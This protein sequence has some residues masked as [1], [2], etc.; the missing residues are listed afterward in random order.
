MDVGCYVID[1]NNVALLSMMKKSK[2]KEGST[3]RDES[4][5]LE[6]DYDEINSMEYG[7]YI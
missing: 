7:L 5:K 2:I 6:K 1:E 4:G 3:K